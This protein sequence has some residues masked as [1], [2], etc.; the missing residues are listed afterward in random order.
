M[1]YVFYGALGMLCVLGLLAGGVAIG[2]KAR[3]TW[4]EHTR[5]AIAEELTEEERRVALETQQAFETVLNYNIEQ[6]YG[7]HKSLDEL[8]R[9][10]D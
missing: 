9:S 2:W 3:G 1:T 8:A 6:A 7:M 4:L 5:K 10:D